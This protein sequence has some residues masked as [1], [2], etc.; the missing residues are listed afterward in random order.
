[1]TETR[2]ARMSWTTWAAIIV[3]LPIA[4]IAFGAWYALAVPGA[5]H[6]GPLPP[7]SAEERD[8]ATRLRTHV[9][10]VASVPHNVKYYAALERAA[11]HIERALQEL[12]YPINRQ[13]FNVDG[14]S[15]RN[16]EATREPRS[17]R[18]H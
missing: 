3:L 6:Q 2:S 15:V 4:V 1:M 16:I 7:A 18:R 9:T 17:G 14:R 12:G 10:A 8:I 5:A 11:V 13:A